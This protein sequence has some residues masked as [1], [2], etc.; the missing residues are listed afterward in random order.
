MNYSDEHTHL[1]N[2]GQNT[3]DL[4]D[5]REFPEPSTKHIKTG[6]NSNKD[7]DLTDMNADTK[8]SNPHE[9]CLCV[10]EENDNSP[11]T[12]RQKVERKSHGAP[13]VSPLRKK[14]SPPHVIINEID[15][16]LW[17]DLDGGW[18]F[19]VKSNKKQ[20]QNTRM[21]SAMF[22]HVSFK[23]KNVSEEIP[24]ARNGTFHVSYFLRNLNSDNEETDVHASYAFINAK[25]KNNEKRHYGPRFNEKTKRKTFK[26]TGKPYCLRELLD[27]FDQTR[28]DESQIFIEHIND[29]K[30]S[31][32]WM[33]FAKNSLPMNRKSNKSNRRNS[34]R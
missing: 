18:R 34:R 30:E 14:Q 20:I 28:P 17:I 24:H 27:L 6:K 8:P 10:R 3:F 13:D 16:S 25:T 26:H 12:D 22:D 33:Q 23:N 11:T 5:L 1:M 32:T 9:S 19:Q 15:Q 31:A 29:L 7:L 21:I 2:T 4:S